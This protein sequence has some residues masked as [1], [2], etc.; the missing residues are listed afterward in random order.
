M[1]LMVAA[2]ATMAVSKPRASG[3]DPRAKVD[4][5]FRVV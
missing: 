1:I 4:Y 3:D 5:P 2:A